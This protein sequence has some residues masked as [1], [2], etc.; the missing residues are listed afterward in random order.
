MFEIFYPTVNGV[1]TSS[2]NLAENLVAQGHEVIFIAPRW[3]AFTEPTVGSGIPVRYVPSVEA[4]VYPGMRN[5]LP[6]SRVTEAILRRHRIDVVHIT[7]PWLLTRS[8]MRAAERIGI[9][10]VHTFHTML[11]EPSYILYAVKSPILVPLIR[12]I[13]WRYY[14]RFVHGAVINTGP[15]RMVVNAIQRHFPESDCRFVSNGVDVSRFETYQPLDALRRAYP[16][17]ND[18]TFLFVGRLGEE[19]SVGELIDAAAIAVREVPEFRL[20]IA[21]DGPGR[22]MYERQVS[23]LGLGRVVRFLGRLPHPDLLA[24]GLIHHARAFVTASTTENQPMTV[25]EAICCGVPAIVPNVPGIRELV[26]DN[27]LL[28]APHD[29][30]SLAEAMVTLARDATARERC[31]AAAR[32]RAAMYDGRTVAARFLEVY[33]DAR[34]AVAARRPS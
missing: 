32:A 10:V 2:M 6:W 21:G 28:A 23:R 7:G 14:R 29:P 18:T 16:E 8:V 12:A 24:S 22:R 11:H 25:I 31:A 1:I 34:R 5:V 20:F 33:H 15:S 17:H 19:K 9:P 30:R 13:A 26:R 27:G 3:S 4:F